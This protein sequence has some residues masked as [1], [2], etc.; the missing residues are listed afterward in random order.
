MGHPLG[1]PIGHHM[2]NSKSHGISHGT[3]NEAKMHAR[4]DLPEPL[5]PEHLVSGAAPRPGPLQSTR[6]RG[7]DGIKLKFA[8]GGLADTRL[9]RGGGVTGMSLS[10]AP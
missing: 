10:H 2:G 8:W 4:P 5:D 6:A 7:Q 3:S 9:W 1:Y